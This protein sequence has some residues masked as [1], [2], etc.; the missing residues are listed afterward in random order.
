MGYSHWSCLSHRIIMQDTP[1]FKQLQNALP[2][3]STD[4]LA[5]FVDKI[6][7]KQQ[8]WQKGTILFENQQPF[9]DLVVISTG[10]VR[11]FYVDNPESGTEIN[12]RFLG[13]NS[14]VLPFAAV[15]ENWLGGS[16][17]F[18][19][20]ETVQCVTDV[21]GFRIS[22]A[23]F[24]ENTVFN[25]RVKAEIAMRHY[26][27]VEQRLRLLKTPKAADRYAMFQATLDACIV[28]GMPNYHVASYLGITPETLSRL[29]SGHLKKSS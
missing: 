23:L 26:V 12:L 18:I 5:H 22:L 10:L 8:T 24:D 25:Q 3:I 20:T 13:D 21:T 11:S 29:K 16:D 27:S 19:A 2:Q 7:P 14:A 1:L 28:N 15:A 6:H 17:E 9:D 4:V